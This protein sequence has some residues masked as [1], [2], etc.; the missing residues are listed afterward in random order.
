MVYP[1]IYLIDSILLLILL[2]LKNYFILKKI[3]L[4]KFI[5]GVC[6][7]NFL[8]FVL[9]KEN[10]ENLKLKIIYFL[11]ISKTF[12][13]LVLIKSSLFITCSFSFLTIGVVIFSNFL[14]EE[15]SNN[16]L[17]ELIMELSISFLTFYFK[18]SFEVI[19]MK[20]FLENFELKKLNEYYEFSNDNK[21][22]LHFSFFENKINLINNNLKNFLES[23]KI[24]LVEKRKIT[25]LNEI[26]NS[27]LTKLTKDQ[28]QGRNLIYV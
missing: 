14:Q 3:I 24:Y 8:I 21:D 26:Q 18:K 23:I 22:G 7:L 5:I 2:K 20:I 16:Y 28:N 17:I 25:N 10:F 9:F 6:S 27:S 15:K 13:Y 1:I 19:S 11:I 4:S 12:F